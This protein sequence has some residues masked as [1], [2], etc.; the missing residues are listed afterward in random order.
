MKNFLI[1]YNI[2][3][4]PKR[5][6]NVRDTKQKFE[7]KK[8]TFIPDILQDIKSLSISSEKQFDGFVVKNHQNEKITFPL[9]QFAV[10]IIQHLTNSRNQNS[11]TS[12]CCRR[13]AKTIHQNDSLYAQQPIQSNYKLN[14]DNKTHDSSDSS[15]FRLEYS[16]NQSKINRQCSEKHSHYNNNKFHMR[17]NQKQFYEL[18]EDLGISFNATKYSRQSNQEQKSPQYKS[19][20][21]TKAIDANN[22]PQDSISSTNEEQELSLKPSNTKQ[23]YNEMNI[24][25]LVNTVRTEIGELIDADKN[26]S[27]EQFLSSNQNSP[28]SS[29]ENINRSE[30]ITKSKKNSQKTNANKRN[31]SKNKKLKSRQSST[32]NETASSKKIKSKTS[33]Q[34]DKQKSKKKN[35]TSKLTNLFKPSNTQSDEIMST[36]QCNNCCCNFLHY[37]LRQI[38]RDTEQMKQFALNT[39]MIGIDPS[40]LKDPNDTLGPAICI[41]MYNCENIRD[42]RFPMGPTFTSISK[43]EIVND[44]KRNSMIVQSINTQRGPIQIKLDPQ[45]F[46]LAPFFSDQ[47]ET[48]IKG[49]PS[50]IFLTSYINTFNK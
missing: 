49:P 22:I 35:S 30:R 50:S 17:F 3:Q 48:F 43:N 12:L 41:P 45:S 8:N 19:G 46:G 38:M 25:E 24:R 39:T 2:L 11:H 5:S 32:S 13:K 6:I 1:N 10:Q 26:K 15:K 14:A 33:F 37:S 7:N 16:S 29:N 28:S 27:K 36:E 34:H 40:K 18:L 20:S 4:T 44:E 9:K 21:Q 31:R 47:Y 42:Q 23:Q